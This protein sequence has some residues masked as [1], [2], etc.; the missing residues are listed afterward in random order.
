MIVPGFG[1]VTLASVVPQLVLVFGCCVSLLELA[2]VL[3]F[4]P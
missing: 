4:Q 2:L 3:C 1:L